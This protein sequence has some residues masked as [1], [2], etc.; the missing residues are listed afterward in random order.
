[1]IYTTYEAYIR[2]DIQTRFPPAVQLLK[3]L[4]TSFEPLDYL[5]K[6]NETCY[7]FYTFRYQEVE[8]SRCLTCC[9]LSPLSLLFYRIYGVLSR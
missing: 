5:P 2:Q 1:M 8:I 4:T 6:H 9:S 3:V 7:C